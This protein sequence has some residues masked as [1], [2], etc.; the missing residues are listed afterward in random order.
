VGLE[1]SDGRVLVYLAIALLNRS[2]SHD[3]PGD[4]PASAVSDGVAGAGKAAGWY[5]ARVC[6]GRPC[7]LDRVLGPLERMIYRLAGC[8]L[9]RDELDHIRLGYAV[10]QPAGAVGSLRASASARCV[11]AQSARPRP[12]QARSG[13]QHGNEFRTNT[14]WQNYGG[15]TT[16]SYLVQM[17]GLTVQNFVSAATGMAVLVALVRGIVRRSA[18]TIG[19]FWWT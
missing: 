3:Q 12:G 14:N 2:G 19:N 9:R 10:V 1:H 17:L 5:M 16:L 4:T 6:E 15:E 11:A 13:L 18:S 8:R 7:G